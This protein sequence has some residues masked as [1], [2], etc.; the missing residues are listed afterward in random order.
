MRTV[1]S[2][3]QLFKYEEDIKPFK[4]GFDLIYDHVVI[5]DLNGNI[6][7]A[8]KGVERQTGY[9][10]EEAIGK[11]PGD[12][13][14]GHMPKEFYK[15]MWDTLKI[16]KQPFISEVQNTRKD[17]TKYWQELRLSP[18]LD[19]NG[20]VKFLIGIEPNITE[21]KLKEQAQR[22]KLRE[23]FISLIGHQLRNP[24]VAIIWS[25]SL[26]SKTGHL[27]KDQSELLEEIYKRSRNMSSLITDLLSLS[28]TEKFE[29]LGKEDVDLVKEIE[30]IIETVK[31][32][33]PQIFFEFKKGADSAVVFT[34]KTLISQVFQN[35]ILNAAE[36]SD[37]TSG[38]VNIN[39]GIADDGWN[40]SCADNGI[41]IPK[42]DQPKIFS[43]FFRSSNANIMKET[44]TGLGLHIVKIISDILGWKISFESEEGK[45]TIFNIIIPSQKK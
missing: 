36:Y 20:E 16:K 19:K 14:G 8:N 3:E 5:T 40:F 24:L 27:E 29:Q 41:G 30:K 33:F 35:I 43:R 6:I 25:L 31:T 39:F 12:L 32:Q 26:L 28:Q 34:T 9:A 42:D 11:N 45:G 38:K 4:A 37:K 22:E 7:Y 17:G 10:A 44:G 21:R 2:Q 18:I 13:W 1:L 23:E 15:E